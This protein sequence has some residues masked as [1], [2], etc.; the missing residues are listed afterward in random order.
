M[1]TDLIWQFSRFDRSMPEDHGD[2]ISP[3]RLDRRRRILGSN[4]AKDVIPGF[5]PTEM[6][7]FLHAEQALDF[8]GTAV[9]FLLLY[10]LCSPKS[11]AHGCE[12][13]DN[14]YKIFHSAQTFSTPCTAIASTK[15]GLVTNTVCV[16]LSVMMLLPL[17]SMS[18]ITSLVCRLFMIR[19]QRRTDVLP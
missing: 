17:R 6:Q 16:L 12:I 11:A 8:S 15:L 18:Q 4:G 7:E 14:D 2:V 5:W 1:P 3:S 9:R 13:C 19:P 10:G